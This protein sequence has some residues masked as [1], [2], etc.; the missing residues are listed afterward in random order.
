M[1]QL[2]ES[3]A[4]MRNKFVPFSEANLS[5]GSAPMLYGLAIYTVIMARYDEKTGKLLLFRM[6]E[7]WE[8]LC[9]SARIMDFRSFL[10]EWDYDRF[11]AVVAEL[12]EANKADHD[13]L[14]RITVF[15]DELMSGTRMRGLHNSVAMFVYPYVPLLNLDGSHLCVSSWQRTNDAAIPSRAKNNGSYTN[16]SLAKNE[17]L[18]NGYDDAVF[19]D[20]RGHVCESTVANIFLVRDSTLITPDNASSLLEGITRRTVRTVAEEFGMLTEARPVDRSEL[21][22]ADEIFLCGSSARIT[23]VLSIDR[24]NIDTGTIGPVSQQF[25]DKFELITT[26]QDKTYASWLT[27]I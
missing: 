25:I 23:P 24:R 27:A 4:Y 17:A 7:H 20:E 13:V 12:V 10:D 21:Y 8:R 6:P 3:R 14:V 11:Q 26:G 5:V 2:Q 9:Q 18:I 19:L 22:I 16:A 15:I 1:Q